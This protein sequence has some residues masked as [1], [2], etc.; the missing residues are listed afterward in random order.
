HLR[1]AVLG[2]SLVNLF[3]CQGFKVT[4][5]NYIGDIGSHVAKCLWALDKF[6]KKEKLPENKGKFLGQVY[7]EAVQ[8]IEANPEFKNQA[9]EVLRK[10]E[11]GDKKWISLWQKTRK[12]SL[13]EFDKIYKTLN[14]R[15]DHFFFES[16]V[17]KPGKKIVA[18]LLKK[19]LAKKSEGAT[20]IDLEKHNLK[21]F[22][23]LKSDGASLYSTKDLALAQLKFKKFKIDRSIVLTDTRQNFYFSQLFKTLEIMGFKQPMSH[24]PYEF[25]TLREG[26]MASRTGN[27]V[28]FEDFF[29]EVLSRAR[30]ETKQRHKEWSEKKINLTAEKIALSA[31]KFGMLKVGNNSVIVF[32]L[33]EA[34]SFDGFSGPYLLYTLS[35]ISSVF[36]K[37][38]SQNAG[39]IDYRKLDTEIEKEILLKLAE[40]PEILVKARK[41]F[42]PSEI[43]KYLFELSRLFANFYQTVPI[44]SSAKESRQARLALLQAIQKVLTDGLAVLGIETLKE[45]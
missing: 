9:D 22:L 2:A 21:T 45:M 31:I 34:L 36:K 14:I 11:Q 37:N 41:G 43:A 5:A 25:V 42:E 18:D 24:V 19:G 16:E 3:R 20:V 26:A 35:R 44:L 29:Q 6:H 23:L 10:L 12:W 30:M 40:F 38:K 33:E 13:D 27:V 7:T 8:K 39:H 1:N 28:L 15:F 17:E 32:D 4:A